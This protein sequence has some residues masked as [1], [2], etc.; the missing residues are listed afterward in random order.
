MLLLII[1]E[2]RGNSLSWR[3]KNNWCSLVRMCNVGMIRKNEYL[4]KRPNGSTERSGNREA[5]APLRAQERGAG[6]RRGVAP[7]RLPS[8]GWPSPWSSQASRPAVSILGSSLPC[9][10]RNDSGWKRH[11]GRK[12]NELWGGT[13]RPCCQVKRKG[14]WFRC[15]AAQNNEP[16]PSGGDVSCSLRGGQVLITFAPQETSDCLWRWQ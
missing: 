7:C 10:S 8:L 4:V 11:G 5:T 15:A 12:Y 1:D 9:L 16:E 3:R 14:V 13:A 2:Q 6:V